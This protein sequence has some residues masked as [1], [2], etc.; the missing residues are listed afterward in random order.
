MKKLKAEMKPDFERIDLQ[1]KMRFKNIEPLD[2]RLTRETRMVLIGEFHGGTRAFSMENLLGTAKM[3]ENMAKEGN[4]P[5]LLII[6]G[7]ILP[8]VPAHI[9]RR[10]QDRMRFLAPGI[11]TVE[12]ASVVVRPHVKRILSHLGERSRTVYVLGEED[13]ENMRFLKDE[14]ISEM[15]STKLLAQKIDSLEME[16]ESL[17]SRL[18]SI[19]SSQ[20]V[21]EKRLAEVA[22][23][24]SEGKPSDVESAKLERTY[25]MLCGKAKKLSKESDKVRRKVTAKDRQITSLSAESGQLNAV[26]RTNTER[27]T[28]E[29]NR[30]LDEE[31]KHVYYD[32]LKDIFEGANLE[33]FDERIN[34]FKLN[35]IAIGLGHN[36]SNTSTSAKKT[37]LALK[38]YVQNKNELYRLHPP[39]DLL[40][41]S[42]HPGTKCWTGPKNFGETGVSVIFQQGSF[43]DPKLISDSWNKAIKL[44][45]TDSVDRYHFDSGLTVVTANKDGSF[46]FDLVGHQELK[47]GA[48]EI[49][50][51]E[52]EQLTKR[53]KGG[54]DQFLKRVNGKKNNEDDSQIALEGGYLNSKLPSELDD[55]QLAQRITLTVQNGIEKKEIINTLAPKHDMHDYHTVTVE[56]HSD[57]HI[58]AGNPLDLYSNYELLEA[59]IADSKARGLPKVLVLAGDMVEGALGTK[60]NEYVARNFIDH[61]E[62]V[63]RL[64]KAAGLTSEERMRARL[65]FLTRQNYSNTVTVVEEQVNRLAPLLKHAVDVVKNGGDVIVVSGNHYNQSQRSENFDEATH[66]AKDIRLLGGLD[67]NDP[68]VHIFYGGWMGSGEVTVQGIPI[69]G[70]HKG[71]GS[72][73]K[74]T[75]LMDHRIMQKRPGF[76]YVEG[77]YHTPVFGKDLAGVFLS[78]PS[79]APSIPF[80]DQAA[81]KAG[82]RGYT[83]LDFFVD[84]IGRYRFRAKIT[85]V[86]EEQ[87]RKQLPPIDENY[88]KVLREMFKQSK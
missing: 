11:N 13:F 67:N 54:V 27:L 44:P 34:V 70:I 36:L 68:H 57:S 82:T 60:L 69:F 41:F 31:V 24:L 29:E 78:A 53:L 26:K 81:L 88:L 79:I 62:F 25:N 48:H 2:E 47:K 58:G 23:N 40:L 49:L 8:A 61:K 17:K 37:E 64:E 18:E 56:V 46:S 12:D 16:R 6:N 7:G 15:K 39:L 5:D 21:V 77:H 80:V 14:K 1:S 51:K 10:N 87:L 86:L 35:G 42:H 66:L 76:F 75:G 43:A 30:L 4:A 20:K 55:H 63:K 19:T 71:K 72:D 84:D 65:E 59:S 33:I 28:P 50:N 52:N 32:L 3:L 9:S 45:Q 85:N 22:Q 73:D 74:I 83:R 38:E